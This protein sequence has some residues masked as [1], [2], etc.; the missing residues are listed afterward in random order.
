MERI[1]RVFK[2]ISN[3]G[4]VLYGERGKLAKV[5]KEAED[6]IKN[7]DG[8]NSKSK[9]D[10]KKVDNKPRKLNGEIVDDTS[11]SK[12]PH[13]SSDITDLLNKVI[14]SFNDGPLKWNPQVD[15]HFDNTCDIGGHASSCTRKL[16][17]DDISTVDRSHFFDA[18][19]NLQARGNGGMS[20]SLTN[21]N[22]AKASYDFDIKGNANVAEEAFSDKLSTQNGK[23]RHIKAAEVTASAELKGKKKATAE[24]N[25]LNKNHRAQIQAEVD[26]TGKA[27]FVGADIKTT[28]NDDGFKADF[29]L[30]HAN[31]DFKGNL[32]ASASA[33]SKSGKLEANADAGIDMSLV[34]GTVAHKSKCDVRRFTSDN[35]QNERS[36]W[37]KGI[38][39]NA[40]AKTDGKIKLGHAKG[41]L[42]Y[43]GPSSNSK[44]KR[45]TFDTTLADIQFE[46][47]SKCAIKAKASYNK[48][49]N[50]KD[51]DWKR[52]TRMHAKA[53]GSVNA[54]SKGHAKLNI[55][56]EE[57]A[58]IEYNAK[59]EGDGKAEFKGF[60]KTQR[61]NPN[62]YEK[63]VK[64]GTG[65][66]EG[67]CKGEAGVEAQVNILKCKTKL[68]AEGKM[69]GEAK[70]QFTLA[71]AKE[72][73]KNGQT[74]REFRLID[75]KAKGKGSAEGRAYFGKQSAEVDATGKAKFV[76]ADIKTTSND[77]GFKAD[78]KLGHANADFKGNL[79]AS[80]SAGSKSGKLEANAD[81]G[82]DMSLVEGTVAHKS[83]CDVRRFTSDNDQNERS[84]WEKGIEINAE[85]KTDGKIKL[86]HAKGH[87]EYSGPSSNSKGKRHTFDTTLADIQFE[88]QSKC[89]IKAK[90]SYN[91]LRN[92][93]DKDWK[94]E[95][96]MHAKAE[97]SVNATSKG[98]AKLNILEEE[99]AK[100]EYNAKFE[101][102]GK[103][104]FKGFE[105][106]QRDNPNG[107]E[108]QVK[109]GTGC[110]EG[111]CKGEAGVEAQVNILKCKTKLGA[112]GKMQGEA[113]AQFTL[114]EAKEIH[115][116]GQ[117]TR[118]FRLIDAKAKGKGSAEGRAY[119]GKQ[120]ADFD[121]ETEGKAKLCVAKG[122][123][124][125]NVRK[126]K[127][128]YNV[129]G[130]NLTAGK[131]SA[132]GRAKGN[133]NANI[134]GRKY[135]RKFDVSGEAKASA[136]DVNAFNV[137]I[138]RDNDNGS[139][140]KVSAEA[141][142]AKANIMNVKAT[143]IEKGTS[144]ET[145]TEFKG[146]EANIGNVQATGI[147]DRKNVNI[148][149]STGLTANIGNVQATG[150][151]PKGVKMEHNNGA[152]IDCFNVAIGTHRTTGMS[153][154]SNR[155]Q[156]FNLNL[157]SG[158]PQLNLN[159]GPSG[160]NFDIPFLS[161][162]GGGGGGGGGEEGSENEGEKNDNENGVD[163]KSSSTTEQGKVTDKKGKDNRRKR[164]KGNSGTAFGC[165]ADDNRESNADDTG[166]GEYTTDNNR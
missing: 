113:K 160:F 145:K 71:E 82:I 137:D 112:E 41:H 88:Q 111:K 70:A 13:D 43:S 127:K 161:N 124:D 25:V 129:S 27:K 86:G 158:P 84:P 55:L 94:R 34:E 15:A 163:S 11:D 105:K 80:A 26:A 30:G 38:E 67:K 23:E 107:Y 37:E 75:A 5:E 63:Q 157:T 77:D 118:E 132:K 4:D 149:S 104:E 154:S 68:G 98:H 91:K 92:E 28:S 62:G 48:L 96:R 103:A 122:N 108:K 64:V 90:A 159:T 45:H 152:G 123:A 164:R 156:F 52:E 66:I 136:L 8:F 59:F 138:R 1:K 57:A 87:L 101:G 35:D 50:E 143:G 65:C 93:T 109:V 106:T 142:L 150:I 155:A 72:I 56:E 148:K 12:T 42:E 33:G 89:A 117:T 135:G 14:E 3:S 85:A 165:S 147:D 133:V 146:L 166:M 32:K 139:T 74:T 7:I 49:R 6:I 144:V 151:G 126:T 140:A 99:A 10:T 83:K 60:E 95:T 121:A 21:A 31:A 54:T 110:I 47:Q 2:F 19:G 131:V 116:N 97:G 18:K 61:D 24:L 128:G 22:T 102:D 9:T 76:G 125:F 39:I 120:S 36:P 100:I 51:K 115:K 46:Q 44:G 119:F 130:L 153:V 141:N 17:A 134:N 81:A 162:G 78:F 114:A 20:L 58:K 53:E 29:K 79:K 16:E 69:Q 73:H 40:E